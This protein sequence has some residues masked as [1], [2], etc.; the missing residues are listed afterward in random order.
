MS[1]ELVL[2]EIN[3]EQRGELVSLASGL[4]ITINDDGESFAASKT[5]VK[6]FVCLL[7]ALEICSNVLRI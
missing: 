6:F 3:E 2:A 7:T 5:P 4:S 1:T